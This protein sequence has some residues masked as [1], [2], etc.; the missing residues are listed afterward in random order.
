MLEQYTDNPVFGSSPVWDRVSTPDQTD[1][2]FASHH[3]RYGPGCKPRERSKKSSRKQKKKNQRTTQSSSTKAGSVSANVTT[4]SIHDILTCTYTT[5]GTNTMWISWKIIDSIHI[6]LVHLKSALDHHWN[7]VSS[8]FWVKQSNCSWAIGSQSCTDRPN[9][10]AQKH[11][12]IYRWLEYYRFLLGPGLF[13]GAEMLLVSGRVVHK[14][15]VL[16]VVAIQKISKRAATWTHSWFW[17]TRT[18]STWCKRDSH[19]PSIPTGRLDSLD[20]CFGIR[21]QLA[22]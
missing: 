11:L 3:R 16:Q 20:F 18:R 1:R 2:G 19:H 6:G 22:I 15:V 13:S 21:H 8:N 12:K 14:N 5:K 7:L 4:Q 17:L 10:Q 9:L